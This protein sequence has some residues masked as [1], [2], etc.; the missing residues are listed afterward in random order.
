MIASRDLDWMIALE[1]PEGDEK[2]S[3]FLH[4]FDL[5]SCRTVAST[6]YVSLNSSIG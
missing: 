6:E 5:Q 2:N 3:V 1:I 4:H